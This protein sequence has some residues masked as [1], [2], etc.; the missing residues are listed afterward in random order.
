MAGSITVTLTDRCD[1]HG[2]AGEHLTFTTSGAKAMTLEADRSP[3]LNDA[4]TDEEAVAFIKVLV[5][6]GKIG[7]TNA[8]VRTLFEAGVQVTI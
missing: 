8:Q 7:R 3:L 1:N 5:K 4:V 6:L 2:G